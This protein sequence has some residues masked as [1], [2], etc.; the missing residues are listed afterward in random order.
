MKL[1]DLTTQQVLDCPKCSSHMRERRVQG[2]LIQTCPRCEHEVAIV[3]SW[4][5]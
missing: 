4:L 1:Q 3:V 5:S 2:G